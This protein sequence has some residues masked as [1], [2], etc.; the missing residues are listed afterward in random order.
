MLMEH[1][2]DK[3]TYFWRGEE[4]DI[5]SSHKDRLYGTFERFP[6]DLENETLKSFIDRLE[7]SQIRTVSITRERPMPINLCFINAMVKADTDANMEIVKGFCVTQLEK[8][9]PHY[10]AKKHWW[11]RDGR[12]DSWHDFTDEIDPSDR[13][14][15]LVESSLG[16]KHALPASAELIQQEHRFEEEHKRA[17]FQLMLEH[18]I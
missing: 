9:K 13:N 17:A 11:N 18:N 3:P 14:R 7:P 16:D 10:V 12:D 15:L 5:L 4:G 2:D 8:T 1:E 6:V